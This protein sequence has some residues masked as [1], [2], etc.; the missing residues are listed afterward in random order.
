MVSRILPLADLRGS[1]VCARVHER[2]GLF[3]GDGAHL[4]R[5]ASLASRQIPKYRSYQPAITRSTR[6][7][8]EISGTDDLQWLVRVALPYGEA[9]KLEHDRPRVYLVDGMS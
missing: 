8:Q 1:L 3:Q 6:G 7:P 4:Q 2:A 5:L 9:R